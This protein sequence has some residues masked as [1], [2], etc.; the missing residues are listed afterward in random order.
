MEVII[1]T[2]LYEVYNNASE[3]GFKDFKN[4]IPEYISSNLRHPL[5]PYQKEAIGRY[6]YYKNDEKN[7][8]RKHSIIFIVLIIKISTNSFFLIWTQRMS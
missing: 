2:F 1:V 7:L 8:F 4:E 5:R 3:G 6:L